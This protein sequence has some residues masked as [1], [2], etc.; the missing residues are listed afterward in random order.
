MCSFDLGRIEVTPAASAALAEAGVDP[1]TYLARHRAGDWGDVE[2]WMAAHN[3]WGVERPAILRSRYALPDGPYLAV[4]TARDRSY[5]QVML[6]GEFDRREVS[7]QEGYA[8]WAETYDLELNPLIAVEEPRVDEILASIEATTALDVCAG[9]GRLA[10]KLARRGVAVTAFDASA[11]MLALAE[12]K[13][14]QEGLSIAFHRSALE[15]G[16]PFAQ[17]TFDL[18]TCALALCHVPGLDRVAHDFHR[19]LRTGGHLL[20]SDFH[21]DAAAE[22][23]WR[24]INERPEGDYLL[25]N[26]PYTRSYYLDAVRAAGFSLVDVQDLPMRA[27][28]RRTWAFYDRM[29]EEYGDTNLCLILLAQKS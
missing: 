27:V 9:T 26:M 8:C 7:V 22:L 29:V 28:P 2:D 11:E 20:I 12:D 4:A 6:E 1:S 5:T 10:L 15:D 25:P 19:V 18:V 21:P 3:A 24:T 23:G 14:R 17:A 16:L 13:A